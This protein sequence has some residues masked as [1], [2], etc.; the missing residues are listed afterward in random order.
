M[1]SRAWKVVV[2][3]PPAELDFDEENAIL[4]PLGA[5]MQ[6]VN[7]TN[8]DELLAAAVDTD[9]IVPRTF[10][11]SGRVIRQMDRCRL[12]AAI[13]IGV[14]PT[15]VGAATER[16]IMVTNMPNILT[17]EVADH[18]WM[19]LLM[20]ARRGLWLHEMA[21]TGRW[22]E[23]LGML[24]P[25]LKVDIPR[26]YGQTLGLIAFGSIARAVAKRAAGFSMRVLAYDPYLGDQVF[27]DAGVERATD[28]RTMLGQCDFVSCHLPLTDTTRHLVG[29]AE[30]RA[31]K[32]GAVF[33]STGRGKVVDEAALIRA[34]H[35]GRLRGA[36]L[37]VL[38]QEPPAVD[39]PL[40]KM[41][42]VVVTPHMGSVSNVTNVERR[43]LL[44]HQIGAVLSGQIPEGIFNPAVLPRWRA[45]W[46]AQE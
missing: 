7:V 4:Q 22:R 23:A 39:N 21:T 38:E 14:D 9:V 25:V 15:D 45:R 6:P 12:I 44:G 36:G 30:F 1:S 5:R 8:D 17:Q 10:G 35:E 40:L 2:V 37:D 33:L 26:V 19:L 27:A 28:L 43:R 16:G 29:E 41:P 18:T 34:L 20:A 11:A 13:G 46:L 42:N 31:M 3:N 32:P 24:F